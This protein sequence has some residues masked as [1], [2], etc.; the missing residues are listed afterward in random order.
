MQLNINSINLIRYLLSYTGE[1]EAD[2][3]GNEVMSQR[4]LSID[5]SSQRR[6]FYKNTQNVVSEF[7][8][9]SRELAEVHNAKVKEKKDKLKKDKKNTDEMIDSLINK[10][11]ELLESL[12]NIQEEVK[13]MLD[14][15]YDIEVTDKTK[16]VIKKYFDLYGKEAG[17]MAG[18][19]E[20]VAELEEILK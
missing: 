6:F 12:K 19:D 4:R 9:K 13:K 10:D 5:E 3:K 17:F 2:G 11:S 20:Q 16:E 1:K 15:K 18:D 7:D 8:K 14:T